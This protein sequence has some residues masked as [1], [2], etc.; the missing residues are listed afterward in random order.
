[1]DTTP[2]FDCPV[3]KLRYYLEFSFFRESAAGDDDS[4]K[5]EPFS[6]SIPL[7]IAPRSSISILGEHERYTSPL[8]LTHY[9]PKSEDA[10]A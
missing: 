8:E 1:M 3:T 5:R 6:W 4:S 9:W 7:T 10:L 2:T